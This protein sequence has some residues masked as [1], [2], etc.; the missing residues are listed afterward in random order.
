VALARRDE[1]VPLG[2][3]HARRFS[4]RA[5]GETF[6]AGYREAAA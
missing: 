3:E 2:L 5:V 4:W 6:L 1:L